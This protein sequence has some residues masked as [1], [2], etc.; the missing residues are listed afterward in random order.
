M[1]RVR[2][3]YLLILI[4]AAI[5]LPAAVARAQDAAVERLKTYRFGGDRAVLDAVTQRVAEARNNASLRAPVA[6]TLG[7]ILQS[8]AAF[9]AKQFACRQLAFIGSEEQVPA[10]APLLGDEQLA[11][12]ALMSLARIPGS[13]V[14]EALRKALPESRGTVKLEIIDALGDRRDRPVVPELREMLRTGEPAEVE[15]AAFALA[16][17]ADHDASNALQLAFL[18]AKDEQKLV[19]GDALLACAGRLPG[20]PETLSSLAIYTMVDSGAPQPIL[21]AGALRGMA[22]VLGAQA[23]TMIVTALKEDRTPRQSAAADLART[24]PGPEVT[25]RLGAALPSLSTRGRILLISA[26]ADRG[27]RS[28]GTDVAPFAS[29]PD[30][31]VRIAAIRALGVLGNPS[32]V[33]TLLRSATSTDKE[34]REAARA[35]LARMTGPGVDDKLVQIASSGEP[36]RRVAAIEAI[37]QRRIAAALPVLMT[38]AK[39]P[40]SEVSS[41]AARV[42]RD[43]AGPQELPTL[44]GILIERP[45]NDRS[46]LSEA[47]A[48]ISRRG[49]TEQQ[50]T[51]PILARLAK[52]NPPAVQ[53]EL[54]SIL[55]QIG[56]PAALAA[57]RAA[58]SSSVAEVR[59]GAA[60]QLAEWPSD[61]AMPD[62]LKALKGSNDRR[63]KTL[64]L[65]GYIRMI[66]LN[67]NR[68]PD[69]A[70]RL[71]REASA[72]AGT[73]EEKRAI[74][75]GI[76]KVR[77]LGA[78]DLA[79]GFLRSEDLHAEAELAVVEIARAT[80]GAYREKTRAVLEPIAASSANEESRNR[81][82]QILSLI[83]KYGD[84]VTA[85]EVSPAYEKAGAI[86]TQLF[87]VLFMP[88][89]PAL[90]NKVVWRLMPAGG[91][92]D[93]PW[94]LDLLAVHGGEQ[95]VA[96]LRTDVWADAGRDAILEMGSDDGIKVWLNGQ[97][98]HSNNTARAAA[99]GQDKIKVTLRQGRNDLLVKV[100]QNIMGWG[101][102][103]R[104]TNVD[105][106]A[107]TGITV[108]L[109]I[110]RSNVN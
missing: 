109:D 33:A 58:M 59:V 10:L 70:L 6:R 79:A 13:S 63:L 101:A 16:K 107:A 67:E 1:S 75:S 72:L 100:T 21:R 85:W 55:R 78:L 18:R 2:S 97:V 51:G 68:S 88:E 81:A 56:G 104:F 61:E 47:I 83:E 7:A 96:Y 93:Q 41:A 27:D 30:A 28:S 3:R 108:R 24:L 5:A 25:K 14:N 20:P 66:G 52:A 45:A 35:S 71:Y 77:S 4:L 95:R 64:A 38:D 40:Q 46:D 90:Q 11:H 65:R 80:A 91:P 50:R 57:I 39:A 42:L 105:G 43:M 53:V 87:D 103:A 34:E 98:V 31:G 9:D 62:L 36:A 73:V 19:L 54:L 26:L 84:F 76:G 29:D 8:D 74:L 60:R 48:A 110:L 89:V 22:R 102:C 15:S 82:K 32:T 23:M 106:S 99:P 12:Y 17:I 44:I 69:E 92:P 37:G 94:L 86:Y 49:V